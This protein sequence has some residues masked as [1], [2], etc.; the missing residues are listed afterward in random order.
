VAQW[1]GRCPGCAGWG[2]IEERGPSGAAGSANVPVPF[3]TLAH[4]PEHEER[5]APSGFLG[6]D[7]V[8]GGGLVPASVTL[9]AGEPG[10]GKSTLL[11]QLVANLSIAGRPCLLASGRNPAGR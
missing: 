9:L 4:D 8:L 3:Q 7:R 2:T 6:I 10:I 1:V 5:R 11:L